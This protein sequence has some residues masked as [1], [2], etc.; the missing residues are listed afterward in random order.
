MQVQVI[1]YGAILQ[2]IRVRD[3]GGRVDDVALGYDDLQ[4]YLTSSPYFGAIVG[5]DANRIAQG[6][7]TLDG[8]T[9][10]LATNNRPHHLHGGTPRFGKAVRQAATFHRGENLRVPLRQT[11]PPCRQG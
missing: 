7:F 4:G 1:T 3:R 6:R 2:A 8:T 9:Y 10:R 11:A 5:R